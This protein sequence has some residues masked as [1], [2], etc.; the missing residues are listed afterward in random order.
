MKK[1]LG[2]SL[3]LALVGGAAYANF[4]ARDYVPAATL[5]VP[6]AVVDL[7]GAGVPDPNGYTTI[8]TVTNVSRTAQLIHVTVWTARS[9][10]V[11]DFD[12][13]LSGYDVWSINFRDLLN[14]RFDYFDTGTSPVGFFDQLPPGPAGD[15][16]PGVDT[17]A[18]AP[19][20]GPSSNCVTPGNLTPDDYDTANLT[21]CNFPYGDLSSLGP[22][23]TA[24]LRSAIRN[25][26][27]WNECGLTDP[28]SAPYWSSLTN[29]PVFFYVTVDTVAQCSLQFPTD[30][31]YF[32]GGVAEFDNVLI[33]DILYLNSA[34]N[35]SEAV[36]AVHLEADADWTGRTFYESRLGTRDDRREPLATAFAFR[37]FNIPEAGFST[38]VI[39]WKNYHDRAWY[40][41]N[42]NGIIDSGEY[43]FNAG[44]GYIYYAFDENENVKSRTGG[45]S[46]FET[47]EPN[48][49]PLETQRVPFNQANWSGLPANAGWVLLVFDPSIRKVTNTPSREYQAW[50]AVKYTFGTYSAAVEAATLGN[51]HCFAGDILPDLNTYPGAPGNGGLVGFPGTG[52]QP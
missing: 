18:P 42:G 52:Q 2:L 28:A 48:N 51:Y 43:F 7:T 36:P 1:I 29:N 40:D 30:V 12:E 22:T 34:A 44:R 26:P 27:Q 37:Y 6:Y 20:W 33:G 21:G 45:P 32:T 46:G 49:L 8:L 5:L 13:V 24:N 41:L 47:T 4:C 15:G 35:Y 25:Y 10:A 19:P 14:G 11:V 38:D 9:A 17:G 23:I 39:V 50:V 3:M 16:V 31:T